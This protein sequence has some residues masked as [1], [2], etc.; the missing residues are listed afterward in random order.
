MLRRQGVV[1]PRWQ[2]GSLPAFRGRLT[3]WDRN[4]P[5]MS[6]TLRVAVLSEGDDINGKAPELYDVQLL[7]MNSHLMVLSG[8]EI[9]VSK[10]NPVHY[11]QTWW[12][13]LPA[14]SGRDLGLVLPPAGPP[15]TA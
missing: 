6:R 13:N 10:V 8:F 1:L 3:V 11:M 5:E 4:M 7:S 14:S 12:I 2:L 15:G 9:D